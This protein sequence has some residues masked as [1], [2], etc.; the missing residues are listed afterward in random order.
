[1]TPAISQD[2]IP[3]QAAIEAKALYYAYPGSRTPAL[4]G[5]T[6]TIN[7]GEIFGLLGPN[8]AGKT[9]VL[10]ILSTLFKPNSG[11]FFI[12]GINAI[13]HPESARE[14]IGFIPQE[15]ALYQV[16]TLR[17]NL[18][19]FGRLCGLHGR[20]L[21]QRITECLEIVGLEKYG[22][23]R[24]KHLS[25]GLKRRGNIAVAM[26][27]KPKVLFLDEPTVGVDIH[28]R[29]LIFNNLHQLK[30]SGMTMIY[31]THYME[32]AQQLCNRIT[33]LDNGKHIAEGKPDD[34]IKKVQGCENL[35]DLF[36]YLTGREIME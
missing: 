18:A 24:V 13:Q 25:G 16:L 19:Y 4:N 23:H 3:I 1:M 27:N 21:K 12:F 7:K 30:T 34:L 32:D 5:L 8:G 17:E 26:I 31:T 15:L 10:S 20:K 6:I 29:K 36:L 33:I 28:T 2:S 14:I 9:T 22:N 35:E 11:E